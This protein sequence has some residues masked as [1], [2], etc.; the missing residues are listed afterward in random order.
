MRTEFATEELL[1]EKIHFDNALP[2]FISRRFGV[3]AVGKA[4]FK[5]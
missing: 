3:L 1:I 4:G 2:G 5:Y